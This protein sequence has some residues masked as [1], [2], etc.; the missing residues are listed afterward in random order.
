[1]PVFF[2]RIEA[3]DIAHMSGKNMVG[4]MVVI[5]NG[6]PDKAEYRKFKIRTIDRSNDVGALREVLQRRFNHDEWQMPNIIVVDGNE[7]QRKVA[8]EILCEKSGTQ[9]ISVVAVVK[10]EHHKPNAIIGKPEIVDKYKKEILLANNEA[11]RFV[12]AYHK[13]LRSDFLR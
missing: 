4:A 7:A 13:K 2:Y 1:M 6:E 12:I 9:N 5:Q 3:Y 10:N 8:E 11:H